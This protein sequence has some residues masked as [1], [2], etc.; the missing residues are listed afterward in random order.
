[1]RAFLVADA[2]QVVGIF[3][4]MS[5]V[6]M[7]GTAVSLTATASLALIGWVPFVGLLVWPVQAAAWVLRGWLFQY[8]SLTSLAAYQTQYRRFAAPHQPAAPGGLRIVQ[9]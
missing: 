5:L 6:S 7:A 1:V 4:V 3:A 8:I 2:R 9:A